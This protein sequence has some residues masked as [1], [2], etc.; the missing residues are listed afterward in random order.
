MSG[1]RIRSLDE[2]SA[3]AADLLILDFDGVVLDLAV[4]WSGLRRELVELCRVRWGGDVRFDSLEHGREEVRRLGS[5][6][7]ADV[8]ALITAH[9]R[10]AV[11]QSPFRPDFLRLSHRWRGRPPAICSSNSRTAVIAALERLGAGMRFGTIVGREDVE[12]VKPSPEGLQSILARER[13]PADRALFV[14]DLRTD[15][16]AGRAAG[17]P[18]LHLVADEGHALERIAATHDYALGFNGAL[19]R[20]RARA[21]I[22]RVPRGGSL[23]DVGGNDGLLAGHLLGH[24][25]RVTILDGSSEY[26]ARARARLG[27]AATYEHGLVEEHAPSDRYDCILASGLLEHVRDP[28]AVLRRMREWLA[29]DGKLV[30]LVPNAGSLHRRIGVVLG[31]LDHP[32]ELQPHDFAVGHRRYYDGPDLERDVRA[33]GLVVRDRGGV[34]LKPLHNAAMERWPAGLVEDLYDLGRVLPDAC[35]EIVLVCDRGEA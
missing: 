18:V 30:V 19:A 6:A 31:M 5:A 21:V 1:D 11:P 23:L 20:Y 12:V 26:L 25:D 32:K 13:V 2:V 29:A 9:E 8:D 24:F 10:R 3:T 17:V 4:D 34:V 7:L 16:Q 14:G 28:V 15:V 35:A 33:A 22:E 27:A